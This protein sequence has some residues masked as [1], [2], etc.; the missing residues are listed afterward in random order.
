MKQE[1]SWFVV[2][3]CALLGL[4]SFAHAQ[5]NC[6]SNTGPTYYPCCGTYN[7]VYTN[8]GPIG[9]VQTWSYCCGS[10][11]PNTILDNPPYCLEAR[12][13]EPGALE[14]LWKADPNGRFLVASCT[15]ALIPLPR[16]SQNW[17]P[18]AERSLPIDYKQTASSKPSGEG[19]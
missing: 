12:L 14:R 8:P 11:A 1:L 5:Q 9:V 10:P 16:P 6:V 13:K 2:S 7:T 3:L 19:M 4:S 18:E 17:K 15:G